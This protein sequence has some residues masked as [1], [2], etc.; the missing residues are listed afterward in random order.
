M[1]PQANADQPVV[2]LYGASWSVLKTTPEQELAAWL[3]MKYFT[4]KEQ[5]AA[6]ATT[7][8]Y[9]AVRQSAAQL[10][11]DNVKQSKTFANYPEA[12]EAYGTMY[13]WIQ[14]GAVESPVAGYDPVRKLI[15]DTVTKVAIKGE[16]DPQAELDAAVEQA[17]DILKEYAP[18]Q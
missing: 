8:N 2:N 3:F 4:E 13:E 1:H 18:K 12:A 16:G 10:A 7:S 6:W 9:M 11:V 15:Q 5:T 14:Y 17:N